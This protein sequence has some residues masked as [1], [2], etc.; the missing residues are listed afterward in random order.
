MFALLPVAALAQPQFEVD[1][2]WP[3]PL[4]DKWI[5]GHVTGL[6]IDPQNRIWVLN[7]PASITEDESVAGA[8]AAPPLVVFDQHGKV[9]AQWTA[10]KR[11][12]TWP[13]REHSIAINP[14]DG[15][16]WISGNGDD[17]GFIVKYGADGRFLM[18]IGS[19]GPSNGSNDS[20]QLGRASGLAIDDERNEL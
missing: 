13:H 1:S 14:R 12:E 4:P 15:S 8:V 9:V 10:A 7:R 17:D 18:R 3:K 2:S 5:L 19:S 11:G 6:A 20:A 16:V